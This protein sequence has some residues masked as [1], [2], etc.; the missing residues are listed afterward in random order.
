MKTQAAILVETGA[1]LVIEE[2]EVP[3]LKP[4]QVLVEIIY[5]GICHTQL[6]ETRGRRGKDAYLPHCLGHEGSGRVLEVGAGV[7][8]VKLGDSVILSWIK[9]SGKDVPGTVYQWGDRKVNAGA[10]TTFSKHAVISENRLTVIPSQFPLKEAALLGCAVPTG[11][12]AVFNTA[13]PKPGQSIA[14]FG[15]G[16]I[17]LCAIAGAAISGCHPI[18]AIDILQDKLEVAKKMGA[19]HCLDASELGY[20]EEMQQI[21]PTLDFA[22]EAT[23]VPSIMKQA[24]KSVRAQGG[25]AVIVGNAPFGSEL[26]IDPKELNQG[27]RLLGTWG[28]DNV[29]DVDFPRYCNLLLSGQLKASNL[30][31]VSY[32]LGQVNTALDHMESGKVLRP[33]LDMSL[34]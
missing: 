12:G 13:Q 21:V 1:P 2:L 30:V 25:A 26:T 18:V 32:S 4:G 5:S 19:T 6:H 28:G 7:S 31:S 8:K 11:L 16:G 33:I 23:G 24:L 29:P 15:C 14:I 10:I 3:A 20:L 9:S 17:G 22:I 27:K 34:V